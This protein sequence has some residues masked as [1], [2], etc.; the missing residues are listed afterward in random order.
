M[1]S[2]IIQV[3]AADQIRER[4]DRAQRYRR[5]RQ[6]RAAAREPGGRARRAIVAIFR[7]RA[8]VPRAVT[9]RAGAPAIRIPRQAAWRPPAASRPR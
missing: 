3:I 5:A 1:Y 2:L 6:V 4:T 8:A 9:L 7:P